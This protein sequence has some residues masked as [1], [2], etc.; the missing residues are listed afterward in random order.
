MRNVLLFM[1]M[2]NLLVISCKKDI[3]LAEGENLEWG[4]AIA[5]Q[6]GVLWQAT[7]ATKLSDWYPDKFS[8][9]LTH[10]NS[11]GFIRGSLQFRHIPIQLGTYY[12]KDYPIEN[13]YLP[14]STLTCFYATSQDDGDVAGDYYIMWNDSS[15][16]IML[17]K[18]DPKT[19]E[20]WG[21]FQGKF[22]KHVFSDIGYEL[23]PSS[24]DTLIFEAGTFH[25]KLNR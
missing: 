8:I 14:D 7:C 17:E 11:K 12:P 1:L 3:Q 4:E 5:L 25:A 24:P 15:T 6:N 19:N 9:L 22:K 13:I 23:D 10:Y 20:I 16:I 2:G 21:S 18:I